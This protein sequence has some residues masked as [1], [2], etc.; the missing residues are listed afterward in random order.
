MLCADCY[1]RRCCIGRRE[2]SSLDSFQRPPRRIVAVQC[3]AQQED[4]ACGRNPIVG[5]CCDNGH[6]SCRQNWQW[7]VFRCG[8]VRSSGAVRLEV[9]CNSRAPRPHAVVIACSRHGRSLKASCHTASPT[10]LLAYVECLLSLSISTGRPGLST[11]FMDQSSSVSPIYCSKSPG[12]FTSVN[13]LT[14]HYCCCCSDRLSISSTTPISII[15]RM[16]PTSCSNL[17]KID[18]IP[19]K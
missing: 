1:S 13:C 2:I 14:L 17:T 18:T 11:K 9:L 10:F 16:L 12:C 15:W 19:Y 7:R 5:A 8:I 6:C 3:K 4:A